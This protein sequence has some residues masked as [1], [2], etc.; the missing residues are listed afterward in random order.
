VKVLCQ[1]LSMYFSYID[2]NGRK[3]VVR[4]L[5]FQP[6]N[7]LKEV[8]CTHQ[9]MLKV[10]KFIAQMDHVLKVSSPA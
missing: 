9:L 3:H 4:L 1:T 6:G 7:L 10:G 2:N 8:P 5:T